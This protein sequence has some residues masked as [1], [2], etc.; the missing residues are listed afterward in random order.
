MSKH[1]PF[2]FCPRSG[3]THKEIME[4]YREECHRGN[5]HG[6]AHIGGGY[7]KII[8]PDSGNFKTAKVQDVKGLNAHSL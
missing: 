8:L 7:P 3:F 2:G 4:L 5:S 1:G 6:V